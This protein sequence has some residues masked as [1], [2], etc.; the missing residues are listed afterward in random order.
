MLTRVQSDVELSKYEVKL[1]VFNTKR[2]QVEETYHVILD[3]NMEAI[4]HVFTRSMAS[5][6]TAA[7]TREMSISDFLLSLIIEAKKVFEALKHPGWI[8]GM[9]EELNQFYR[10][11][12]ERIDY[13]ETF[14]TVERMEGIRIFLSFA[15]WMNFTVFQMDVKSA[16]LNGD[17]LLIQVYVDDIIFG[18]TRYKL[19]K[20]FEKLMTKKFEMCMMGELTYFLGLQI[21]HDEKGISICQEQYTR[22]L[23]KKYEISN[24]FSVK[25]PMVPPNNLGPDLDGKL[26]NETSYRGMIGSL[27][28]LTATRPDIQFSTVLCE[29]YQSNPKE[30][31]LTAVKR[32]LMYLKGTPTLRLYCLKC[33]GFDLKG[34]LDSDYAGCNMDKKT[35]QVPAKYLVENLFVRVNSSQWLCSQLRLNML[36]LLG[37]V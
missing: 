26:V 6:L 17:V 15:T 31:H 8:N 32:I 37:V 29:R 9:Q 10:N 25:T 2:Q 19:C 12:E 16:F 23:L 21:K 1:R 13:D 22:N 18:T 3:E 20:Q 27:M 35:P 5:K 33:L 7:T 14:A 24:S 28:Y 34:Y 11:K 36:L 4:R 30:S